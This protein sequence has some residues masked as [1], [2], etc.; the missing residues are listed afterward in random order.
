[1]TMRIDDKMPLCHSCNEQVCLKTYSSMQSY[2][3]NWKSPSFCATEVHALYGRL[4]CGWLHVICVW[5]P[6][7]WWEVGVAG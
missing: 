3:N 4:S 7:L 1:M 2:T 5:R 6:W